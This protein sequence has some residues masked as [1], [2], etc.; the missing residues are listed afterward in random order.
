MH[1]YLFS[2]FELERLPALLFS[3]WF[4]GERYMYLYVV[5]GWMDRDRLRLVERSSEQLNE[6]SEKSRIAEE[7]K[8]RREGE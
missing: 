6:R 8:E 2:A 7:E 1:G 5:F 4:L 3:F